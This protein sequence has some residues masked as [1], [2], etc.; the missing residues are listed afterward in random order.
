M[1][2][3]IL[4]YYRYY[5]PYG[6]GYSYYTRYSPPPI[7][8]AGIAAG[9]YGTT[10]QTQPVAPSVKDVTVRVK[11]RWSGQPIANASVEIYAQV[12]LGPGEIRGSAT[13]DADGKAV[14]S[15]IKY[16]WHVIL[17]KIPGKP[18]QGFHY[19]SPFNTSDTFRVFN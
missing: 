12:G 4:E 8:P 14:I 6:S 5:R 15:G 19:L 18:F 10:T 16:K 2:R 13:T 11:D 7:S 3:I 17:V 9:G 1:E